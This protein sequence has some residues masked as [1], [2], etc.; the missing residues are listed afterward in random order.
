VRGGV[1]GTGRRESGHVK[2]AIVLFSW[3][4]TTTNGAR[5]LVKEDL[6]FGW[7]VQLDF[8]LRVSFLSKVTGTGVS[9]FL[10]FGSRMFCVALAYSHLLSIFLV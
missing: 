8:L 5:W 1:V 2:I 10:L 6:L 4:Q 3:G 7:E 9:Q